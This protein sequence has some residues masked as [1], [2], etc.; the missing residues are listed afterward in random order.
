MLRHV[1]GLTKV[2]E[3]QHL[4]APNFRV[5]VNISACQFNKDDFEASILDVLNRFD[6]S[7]TRI[8]LE[9]TE[10]MLLE[11]IDRAIK[12]MEQL[13]TLG[14]ELSIDDFGTGYKSLSY[15]QQLPADEIKIDKSFID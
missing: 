6:V 9:I 13:R 7:P 14:F 12:Q 10:G 1:C 5:A 8:T 3:T 11:D 2:I 15:L 4:V